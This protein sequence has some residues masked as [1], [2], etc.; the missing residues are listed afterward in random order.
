MDVDVTTLPISLIL[1]GLVTVLLA[2]TTCYCFVLDRRLSALRNGRDELRELIKGL[3]ES[4][5]KAQ[6]SV[7]QLK[8][9]GQVTNKELQAVIEKGRILADELS[10]MIESGN[11]IADRLAN[12]ATSESRKRA[13]E[14]TEKISRQKRKLQGQPDTDQ[15]END[16]RLMK[17]LQKAR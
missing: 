8:A 7:L 5:E 12:T 14:L 15:S 3:S 11:N 10:M 9:T 2:V 4:V 13:E 1:E 16:H 6:T 17:A